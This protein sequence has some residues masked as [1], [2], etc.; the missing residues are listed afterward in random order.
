[1]TA[2]APVRT[3]LA[4]APPSQ[5]TDVVPSESMHQPAG[6]QWLAGRYTPADQLD[7]S[8]R[9]ELGWFLDEDVLAPLP[10][11]SMLVRLWVSAEGR[12]DRVELLRADPPGDW[13]LRA[14]VPLPGTPMRPGARGGRPVAATLV[15]ELVS[16]NERFR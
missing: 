8:P 4:E 12:I 5:G 9:P 15:V 11:G 1:M 13:A 14:L 7:Q 10:H 16:D 2:D 6:P 3:Q